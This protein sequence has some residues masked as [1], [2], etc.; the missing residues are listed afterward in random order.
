[1]QV[2]Q[3]RLIEA[4]GEH[5]TQ[6][7]GGTAELERAIVGD[8][9]WR[10][11]AVVT[12]QEFSP[13]GMR[14]IRSVCRLM[15]I[16]NPMIKR[17]VNLRVGYVW[18]QGC[19]I[20]ARAD[21]KRKDRKNEQDVAAVIKAHIDDP[22]N[23]RAWWGQ[24]AREENERALATDGE[25]FAALF[26][27][28]KTGWVNV[29]TFPAD[30]ISEVICNPEDKSEPW[31][32][33]RVFEV[34]THTDDGVRRPSTR[35]ILYPDVDYKPAGR[36]PP[37]YA[38]VDVQWDTPVVH[39]HVNRPKSW[40]RGIPDVYSVI[41]WARAYKEF[42]EQWAALMRSL[43]KFAWRLTAEGRN[44]EQAKAAI[45]AAG[46]SRNALGER[47]DVGGTAITPADANLEAIP[48]TGATIDADS[49]RPVAAMVAA[50]LDLPVTM[51]LGDPGTTGARATA[52]TLDWPT[53]LAM[54]ARRNVWAAADQR[55][56]A[57]RIAEA[58]RAS[59]GGLKGT[60]KRDPVTGREVVTLAGDTD[61]TVDIVWPELDDVDPKALIEA[62]AAANGTGTLPPEQV[63]R[64]LL[65][66]FRILDVDS[67]L[68]QM[69]D[70]EGN[71]KWPSSP[72]TAGMGPGQQAADLARTGADPATAG[73]GSMGP[74]GEPMPDPGTPA[75]PNTAAIPTTEQGVSAEALARQADAEFG[76]FGSEPPVP[77]DGIPDTPAAALEDEP[78]T[79]D[80]GG[81]PPT[82]VLYDPARFKI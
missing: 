45:A 69:V 68:D 17:G 71:F 27:S 29:R 11:F 19:Q 30:E 50:G 7:A 49:G 23:Q 28:P 81:A 14:Q 74:D 40:L 42:L 20:V 36:K 32:Y 33:R 79:D 31:F 51:L 62:V 66:A 3:Q 6:E 15:S 54:G 16:A 72:M 58:V 18:G 75:D 24:Q 13:E 22:A 57:Y 65:Q 47:N 48:K 67:I 34:V 21:G 78:P 25:V 64:L 61:T 37:K 1:M 82:R 52:E 38:G 44:R 12:E 76:L 4:A 70:E 56:L 60:I 9:G 53:E 10:R 63:L 73:P 46:T 2:L 59:G 77:D 8:P 39:V 5:P 26:T 43:A 41:N 35:E 55:I 80:A